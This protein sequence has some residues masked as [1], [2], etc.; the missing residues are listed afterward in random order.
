M[1]V[2]MFL[3]KLNNEKNMYRYNWCEVSK[4]QIIVFVKVRIF[5]SIISVYQTVHKILGTLCLFLILT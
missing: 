2:N 1:Y 3:N 5:L 4:N